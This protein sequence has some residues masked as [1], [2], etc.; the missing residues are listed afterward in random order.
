MR[1][2]SK[3]NR[4]MYTQFFPHVLSELQFIGRNSDPFIMLFAPN[5]IGQ[6]NYLGTGFFKSHLK[7]TRMNKALC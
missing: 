7:T 4:A 2:K 5:A 3:T 1:S 6:S